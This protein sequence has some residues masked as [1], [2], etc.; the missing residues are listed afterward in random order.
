MALKLSLHLGT[1]RTASLGTAKSSDLL[2]PQCPLANLRELGSVPIVQSFE[3]FSP[4]PFRV[5]HMSK[6][7]EIGQPIAFQLIHSIG[8]SLGTSSIFSLIISCILPRELGLNKTIDSVFPAQPLGT[9]NNEN[10]DTRPSIA[11]R[12]FHPR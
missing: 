5:L 9:K 8:Q 2:E 4:Q 10:M 7:E 6:H 3:K 11:N 1:I 12:Q